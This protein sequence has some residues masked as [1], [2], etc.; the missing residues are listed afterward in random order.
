MDDKNGND[1][2]EGKLLMQT[3]DDSFGFTR[4]DDIFH[5]SHLGLDAVIVPGKHNEVLFQPDRFVGHIRDAIEST[6]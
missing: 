2:P 4:E 3:D 1:F 5:A 6:N